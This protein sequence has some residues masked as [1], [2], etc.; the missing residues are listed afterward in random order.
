MS[1]VVG[2]ADD[3][4]SGVEVITSEKVGKYSRLERLALKARQLAG[5]ALKTAGGPIRWLKGKL[6]LTDAALLTL[7]YDPSERLRPVQRAPRNKKWATFLLLGG[8]GAGKSF[9]AAA[10]VIETARDDP[11]A[12]ILLVGP[13]YSEIR[14]NQL[15]G[16]S[17]IL[18][19]SPP[20]F[21]PRFEKAAKALVWPNGARADII[22]VE[23]GP[24]KFRGYN[25]SDIWADEPV[26]WGKDAVEVYEQ[27]RAVLR[28][29]T[30]R[31][32]KAKRPARMFVTSTPAPMEVFRVIL[33]D[34]EGL[35]V[36][37]S[38]TLENATNLDKAYVRRVKRLLTTSLGKREFGGLL[39]FQ[40]AQKLYGGVE[41]NTGRI[42]RLEDIPARKG[43]PLFD[44]V[45][46]SVDPATGEMVTADAHGIVVVGIRTEPDG[47]DHVYVLADR[48]LSTA[49][50]LVWA[51]EVVHAYN[52]FKDLAQDPE[53]GRT[54]AWVFAETN[55][56]GALVK[57]NIR[58]VDGA[59]KVKVRRAGG[60][61]L[62]QSKRDR[63]EPVAMYCQAIPALV[64]MVGKHHLLEAQLGAFTG[65]GGGHKRDDRADAFA[66]PIYLYVVP[67]R[68]NRGAAGAA[69][70]LGVGHDAASQSEGDEED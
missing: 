52:A 30:R 47:F 26:V 70:G 42:D 41:W 14:K 12:R 3:P 56:G 1:D 45:I 59:V 44:K 23:A 18:T 9:A 21:R 55:T 17:G 31:M 60:R 62:R 11:E 38:G 20:W 63:H 34:K 33:A 36:A 10:W 4:L 13:T 15:E 29:V 27:C 61:G 46:V 28:V 25:V 8:R 39:T 67:R 58:T 54:K 7:Y 6:G 24:D 43:K 69:A 40:V 2:A 68:R 19:L 37:Q 51:A 22:P 66:W 64:H 5:A 57:S 35:V 16:P 49:D 32:R 50:P 48:S 65:E 53:S